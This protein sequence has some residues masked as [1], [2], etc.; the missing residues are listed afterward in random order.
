[1]NVEPSQ[2]HGVL[3]DAVLEGSMATKVLSPTASVYNLTS[4]GSDP[5]VTITNLASTP[6]AITTS[7][8]AKGLP[9]SAMG[10]VDVATYTKITASLP[11]NSYE[12]S[13]FSLSS[14]EIH[15]ALVVS[16]DV[17]CRVRFYA[18]TAQRSADLARP[19]GQDAAAANMPLLDVYL[20]AGNLTAVLTP[21]ATLFATS[22]FGAV[23]VTIT[24]RSGGTT[25]VT[26]S[27]TEKGI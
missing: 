17:P 19:I 10:G 20:T 11:N 25:T 5:W 6:Q 4:F 14:A 18:T 2:G 27:V 9:G 13:L 1:M 22:N 15:Q 12:T 24:N 21:A 26:V 8:M 3:L 16:A 23:P 7:V